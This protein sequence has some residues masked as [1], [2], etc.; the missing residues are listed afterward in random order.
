MSTTEDLLLQLRETIER[1]KLIVSGEK[2]LV[3]VSGGADSVALAQ[4][5]HRLQSEFNLTFAIAHL[6]HQLRGADSDRDE[7]F[8][9]D[10]ARSLG[11]RAVVERAD[12]SEK[13]PGVHGSLQMRARM[14]RY[15]FYART[16]DALQCTKIALGH[17]RDDVVETLLLHIF[18]GTA[19]SGLASIPYRRER[20]IR[21]LLDVPRSAILS[22]LD[23][24]SCEYR[25]DASNCSE[26][27]DRN[28]LRNTI[29]PLVS[30]RFPSASSHIAR[31]AGAAREENAVWHVLIE[32]AGCIGRLLPDG[33]RRIALP[34]LRD[35]PSPLALR[36]VSLAVAGVTDDRR[37][38]GHEFYASITGFLE[39]PSNGRI[40]FAGT[41]LAIYEE[42]DQLVISRHVPDSC[43]GVQEQY[44][45]MLPATIS[46]AGYTLYVEQVTLGE[47]SRK[48]FKEKAKRG[49]FILGIPPGDLVL[50]GRKPGDRI[51]LEAAGTRKIKDLLIGLKIPRHER[52]RVVILAR[53]DVVLGCFIPCCIEKS[54]VADSA[55]LQEPGPA[56][57]LQWQKCSGEDA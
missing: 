9:V 1:E 42:Y 18:Q 12:L 48:Y 22:F 19:M 45:D 7:A 36:A 23:E 17:N 56:L 44:L 32:Q 55:L 4:L 38:P 29:L 47:V 28:W 57:R 8:T 2:I 11:Y 40:W 41:S 37:G 5:L 10:I 50:R 30:R 46:A 15:E 35:A 43:T 25:I 3:A 52:E 33:S 51:R 21:P 16:A 31:L 14:V 6:N 49:I 13:L 53:G 39:K 24:I 20:Y 54:R 26:A 27:Y 34:A